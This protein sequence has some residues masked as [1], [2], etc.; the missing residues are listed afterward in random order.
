[1]ALTFFAPGEARR[2]ETTEEE[3]RAVIEKFDFILH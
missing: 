3:L 2:L 1:V